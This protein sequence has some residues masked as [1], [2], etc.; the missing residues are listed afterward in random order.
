M[1]EAAS[2]TPS[3]SS[4]GCKQESAVWK[5]FAYNEEIKKSICQVI[6]LDNKISGYPVTSKNNTNLKTHLHRHHADKYEVFLKD[7]NHNKFE[8]KKASGR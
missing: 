7:D 2:S 8:K 5:Y 4:G 1:A 3:R 6:T